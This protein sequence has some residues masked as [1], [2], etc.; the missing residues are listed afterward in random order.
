M[1]V[2]PHGTLH[3]DAAAQ[4]PRLR[5][6]LEAGHAGLDATA[7]PWR[8]SSDA[9][10]ARTEA[11]RRLAA[12]VLFEG[13]IDGLAMLPSAAHGLAIAARNAPLAA[14]DAVLLQGGQF[15]SNALPWQQRC[16]ETGARI[17]V[18]QRAAGS[19][20]TRALLDAMDGDP[21][22]TVVAIDQAHWHDGT[23]VDIGAV[24]ARTRA[25]GAMLVLD[26]SQ[27]LGALRVDL[28]AWQPDFIVAVG[29]KWLLGPTG[30]AWSWAAPRWRD[31]GVSIEQHWLARD[32]AQVWQAPPDATPR[33]ARGARR[34][35]AG[36]VVD[37]PRLAMAQAALLQLQRWGL[38]HITATLGALTATLDHALHAHGLAAWITPGHAPHFT[39]L[40]P[41]RDRLD[42]LA[43]AL[44]EADVVCTVRSG[45]VRIAPHLHV[46]GDDMRRVAGICARVAAAG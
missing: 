11:L 35:D 44:L 12:D 16:A 25:S 10:D 45:V 23:L 4:G 38:P 24:A 5:A 8:V 46:S 36:G 29:Y 22:I 41:P 21:R 31:S 33:F 2:L 39:A 27:S 9:W 42:A 18:A 32:A 13:D 7:T 3:L 28:A 34:F 17:V 30:L 20:A 15:P 1:F 37:M 6:V 14:G 40:R 19:D 43:A 26:L